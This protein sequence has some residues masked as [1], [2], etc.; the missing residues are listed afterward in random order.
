[1]EV[2]VEYT[3]VVYMYEFRLDTC[4]VAVSNHVLRVFALL[5]VQRA[6][7]PRART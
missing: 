2:D 1:M 4:S 3:H 7:C 5:P 6:R